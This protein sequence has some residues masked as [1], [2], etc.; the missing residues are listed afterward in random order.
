MVLSNYC[1]D[2]N[3]QHAEADHETEWYH[4]HYASTII[5]P[6]KCPMRFPP[7]LLSLNAPFPMPMPM[8]MPMPQTHAL[9]AQQS[10]SIPF[11]DLGPPKP[12]PSQVLARS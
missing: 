5:K 11:V 7:L 6:L 2:E 10:L 1:K 9:C 8:P 3:S 4:I 12:G